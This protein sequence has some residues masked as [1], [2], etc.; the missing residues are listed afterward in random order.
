[1]AKG[2]QAAGGPLGTHPHCQG[3]TRRSPFFCRLWQDQKKKKRDLFSLR[4]VTRMR[5]VETRAPQ[6]SKDKQNFHFCRIITVGGVCMCGCPILGTLGAAW[7]AW[8]WGGW[9]ALPPP[10]GAPLGGGSALSRMD[11]GA[12]ARCHQHPLRNMSG[13]SRQT[14]HYFHGRKE[15]KEV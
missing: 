9:V 13:F 8:A 6:I 5:N 14:M 12:S 15:S 4:E 3:A 2:A 10:L 11:R 7:L 1:M